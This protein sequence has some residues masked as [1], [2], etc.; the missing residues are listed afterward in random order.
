MSLAEKIQAPATQHEV[1]DRRAD[2]DDKQAR[3]GGLLKE[4]GC[5]GLLLFEPENFAWLTS[6][7][8]TR[9]IFDRVESP[10]LFFNSDQ[11]WVKPMHRLSRMR[12][13]Q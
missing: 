9:G 13:V 2:I 4:T 6:G 3:V 8:T 1:Q 7:G 10:I 5:E 12:K 11:R